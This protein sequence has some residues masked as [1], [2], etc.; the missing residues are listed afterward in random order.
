[1]KDFLC[2]V[3]SQ[4]EYD[5]RPFIV[6]FFDKI[7]NRTFFIFGKSNRFA[8]CSQRHE[9]F[10]TSVEAT[11]DQFFKT[12]EVDAPVFMEGRNQGYPGSFQLIQVHTDVFSF[13]K[14]SSV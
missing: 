12:L 9:I 5:R 14:Y 1:M 4:A 10:H 3:A 2:I 8:G 13:L 11:V 6:Y 7:D